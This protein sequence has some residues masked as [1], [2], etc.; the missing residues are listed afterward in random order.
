MW[1][2]RV[3]TVEEERQ[4]NPP[5]YINIGS[6]DIHQSKINQYHTLN[7]LSH[8]TKDHKL[9]VYSQEKNLSLPTKIG[10]FYFLLILYFNM[11]CVFT[12]IL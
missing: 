3:S 6:L 12:N 2:V 11:Y 4:R 1:Q 7:N 10:T 5:E 8:T 9:H